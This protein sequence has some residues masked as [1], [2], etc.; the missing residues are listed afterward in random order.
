MTNN[1]KSKLQFEG[2]NHG[3]SSVKRMVSQ[4]LSDDFRQECTLILGG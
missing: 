1:G 3:V 4:V 2:V